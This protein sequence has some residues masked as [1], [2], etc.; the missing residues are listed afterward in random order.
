MVSI[1]KAS[2]ALE[3]IL[4]DV[5]VCSLA[6]YNEVIAIVVQDSTLCDS[7]NDRANS[8]MLFIFHS[9]ELQHM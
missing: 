4:L 7:S 9:I 2:R 3:Q 1:L 8:Y 5:E 6:S